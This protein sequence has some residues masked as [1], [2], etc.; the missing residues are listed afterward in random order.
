TV[1]VARREQCGP[2]PVADLLPV[3]GTEVPVLGVDV[4]VHVAPRDVARGIVRAGY[5]VVVVAHDVVAV[6]K[7]APVGAHRVRDTG[8]EHRAPHLL[9]PVVL[10]PRLATRGDEFRIGVG[11]LDVACPVVGAHVGD[12]GPV[13]GDPGE[14]AFARTI[15]GAGRAPQ[16]CGQLEL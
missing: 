16:P 4:Q 9:R 3:T 8:D 5:E 2:R 6:L 10:R 14:V 13:R 15:R 12:D 7:A 1:P 11:G